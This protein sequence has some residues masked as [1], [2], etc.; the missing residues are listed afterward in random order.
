[1][2][3]GYHIYRAA[4]MQNNELLA[5]VASFNHCKLF[6]LLVKKSLRFTCSS[7]MK[8]RM[9]LILTLTVMREQKHCWHMF[10]RR[11]LVNPMPEVVVLSKKRVGALVMLFLLA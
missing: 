6:S 7:A 11:M 10:C 2:L 8:L 1:M 9:T 4:L 5:E 3:Q